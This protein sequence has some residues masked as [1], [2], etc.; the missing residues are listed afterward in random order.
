MKG[1]RFMTHATQDELTAT[2]AP[3][4]D[5]RRWLA[6]AVVVSAAF[7]AVFDQF[8]VNVAIPTM[9]R[10][11]H[12]SF[13]QIQFVIAGYALAYAVTLITGG[14][15]GD[16]YGRKRLFMLGMA[17]FTLASALCGLAPGPELLVGARLVQ[18]IGAALMSPQV[19]SIIQVTF[20]PNERGSA[21]SVYGAAVGIASL[22]GQALGGF[23]IRADLFGL[24]W[25]VVFLVNIPIGIAALIAAKPLVHETRSPTALKL[26]LGGVA[27]ITGG[28]FLLTFPLV[29]GR[30]AGWPL[31]AWLCLIASVPVIAGFVR[32]E[33]W[34]TARDG[35][36]L[37]VLSLF[38][39]RSFDAGLLVAFFFGAA[40]PAM[41]FT[42]A[43]YLQIGLHFSPLAAGLTFAPAP[44]GFF[45]AA[46]LSGRLVRRLGSHL[47]QFAILMKAVAWTVIGII[48]HR[49]GVS[50]HGA[51]LLPF[52][53]IE[54]A[55]AGWTNPPLIGLSL[56]GVQNRDAGSAAGVLT[57]VQ[58]IAGAMGV[59]IIG[60]IF[61]GALAHHA[62]VVSADLA[63]A[64]RQEIASASLPALAIT[65]TVADFQ[66]CADDRARSR[67]P[68]ITPTSCQVP[69]L[70]S[71][72]PAARTPI[73]DALQRA[74]ARNYA[75]AYVT[76]MFVNVGTLLVALVCAFALPAPRSRT[77]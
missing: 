9:Q 45:L 44:V 68:A 2:S 31:W 22:A 10:D 48:A 11:L 39:E 19:L 32:F 69:T 36:P 70:Q 55:G 35:A 59:A 56:A 13:A 20:P 8:V 29:E 26:D 61:F 37:V 43:L 46:T 33:R 52:M 71:P 3:P 15:L 40:N 7:M 64:L 42:L 16:I 12:A 73:A 27:I 57:T 53:F 6:L 47:V 51:Q 65:S 62:P 34:K 75:D 50:L 1:S 66:T 76:A 72:D 25:R 21:L 54:G 67:D 14:R 18:G 4:V 74:N 23:L 30:D 49:N 38:R 63:P 58:Q 28:L 41:F 5:R 60:V 77:M 24:S 17:G